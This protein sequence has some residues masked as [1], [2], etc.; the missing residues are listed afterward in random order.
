MRIRLELQVGQ[1]GAPSIASMRVLVVE[2]EHSIGEFIQRGL[3]AEGYSV[4]C[5]HDGERGL[6]MAKTGDYGL[7]VLDVLLP[8]LGGHEVIKGIREVDETVPVIMLTALAE[9]DDIV[10]GLDLGANDYL[11]KP[12]AFAELLARIRAHLRAPGQAPGTSVEVGR[13][14]LD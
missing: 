13:L 8:K 11:T 3:E 14:N 12:F 7:I 9:T 4:S 10:A 1:R 6:A 5:A 2:D